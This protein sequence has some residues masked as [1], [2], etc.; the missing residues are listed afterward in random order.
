MC[1]PFPIGGDNDNKYASITTDEHALLPF[2]F[3]NNDIFFLARAREKPLICAPRLRRKRDWGVMK[4]KYNTHVWAKSN[5]LL[6][7][8]WRC[9]G[10][11]KLR[12][13]VSTSV[14]RFMLSTSR[15]QFGPLCIT[16]KFSSSS[17]KWL[18]VSHII[19]YHNVCALSSD[20]I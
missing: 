18:L 8:R 20:L 1:A 19:M 2:W 6:L 9:L 12:K 14:F 5:S 13:H 4:W 7:G 16:R 17:S 15:H 3:A 10:W 11:V